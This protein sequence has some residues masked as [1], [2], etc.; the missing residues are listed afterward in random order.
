M[1]VG[2]TFSDHGGT[3]SSQQSLMQH[4]GKNELITLV[5]IIVF[6]SGNYD[7]LLYIT[8]VSSINKTDRH[9][10]TKILLKVALNTISITLIPTIRQSLWYLNDNA[11]VL[12]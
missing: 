9:Y 8:P 4:A 1:A 6:Y 3:E 7:Y 5:M 12:G 2:V 10:I 11:A